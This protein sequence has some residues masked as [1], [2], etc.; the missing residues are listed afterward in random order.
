MYSGPSNGHGTTCGDRE[1]C[2]SKCSEGWI[3]FTVSLLLPMKPELTG[4]VMDRANGF[5]NGYPSGMAKASDLDEG[6]RK[7]MALVSVERYNNI[8]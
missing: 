5:W 8:N 4:Q 2:L 3:D 1:E 6:R 7:R